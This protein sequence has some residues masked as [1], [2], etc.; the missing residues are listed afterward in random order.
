MEWWNLGQPQ[1]ERKPT[2]FKRL[3]LRGRSRRDRSWS[4][5]G[6]GSR[7]E[8]WKWEK[9]VNYVGA[10][11]MEGYCWGNRC[12]LKVVRHYCVNDN[13]QILMCMFWMWS[14]GSL[15]FRKCVWNTQ[16]WCH[17][18]SA[19]F[20]PS[21]SKKSSVYREKQNIQ[22]MCSVQAMLGNWVKSK[23]F[24]L[25]YYICNFSG[26]IWNSFKTKS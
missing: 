15:I 8:S 17:V 4:W 18:M 14:T 1:T 5:T 9:L 3:R 26:K 25:L 7:S 16:G 11:A 12:N 19:N 10:I 13:S 21:A 6:S 24:F 20:S 23:Q 2:L 22:K